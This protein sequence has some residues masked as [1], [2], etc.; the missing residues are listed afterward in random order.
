MDLAQLLSQRSLVTVETSA[1]LAGALHSRNVSSTCRT[2]QYVCEGQSHHK[3]SSGNLLSWQLPCGQQMK[4]NDMLWYCVA[5][6][7]YVCTI[8]QQQMNSKEVEE[9][10]ACVHRCGTLWWILQRR[11]CGHMCDVPTFSGIFPAIDKRSP[12]TRVAMLRVC[13]SDLRQVVESE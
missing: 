7:T 9:S 10:A 12:T 4:Q 1:A 5:H 6:G 2:K 11:S 8:H 3:Q 13:Q